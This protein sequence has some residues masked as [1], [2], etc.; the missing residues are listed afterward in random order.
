[1]YQ[2]HRAGKNFE[3]MIYPDGMHGYY[4]YQGEHFT[5]ANRA[6]WLKYLKTR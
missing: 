4:G 6:F 3:F 2:M 5:K 1:M